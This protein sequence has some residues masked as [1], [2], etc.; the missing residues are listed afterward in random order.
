MIKKNKQP[1]KKKV[2]NKKS[3]EK[4]RGKIQTAIRIKL[5]IFDFLLKLKSLNSSRRNNT[6]K[7]YKEGVSK[8]GAITANKKRISNNIKA[9]RVRNFR[10][11]NTNHTCNIYAYE[12]IFQNVTISD[13]FSFCNSSTETVI[14]SVNS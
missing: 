14:L 13:C 6:F 10:S 2:I 9:D 5:K 3:C 8:N 7:T 11:S 1:F 4:Y 12:F